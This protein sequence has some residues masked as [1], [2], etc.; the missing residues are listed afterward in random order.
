MPIS[1]IDEMSKMIES[2]W[3]EVNE[4]EEKNFS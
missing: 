3:K 1:Y 2:L 4:N